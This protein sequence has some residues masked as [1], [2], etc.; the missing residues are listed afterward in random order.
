MQCGRAFVCKVQLHFDIAVGYWNG[1]SVFMC[2]FCGM[3]YDVQCSRVSVQHIPWQYD[4]KT[5]HITYI[6]YVCVI[7][8]MFIPNRY[9]CLRYVFFN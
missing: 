4:L 5:K 6:V 9:L 2:V 3:M 1:R 7:R 8:S